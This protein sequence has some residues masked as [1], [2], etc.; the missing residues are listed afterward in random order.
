MSEFDAMLPWLPD[1]DLGEWKIDTFEVDDAASRWSAVRRE[2]VPPGRYRR[3]KR[4]GGVWM[5]TT[6]FEA[7][8][9]IALF[10]QKGGDILISGLGLGYCAARVLTEHADAKLT[11]VELEPALVEYVGG[12]LQAAFPGRAEVICA[13]ILEWKPP[14]G[15]RWAYAWHDIWQDICTDNLPE[16]ARLKRRFARRCNAQGCWS[17]AL[18]RRYQRA[19]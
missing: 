15:K 14:A 13:D 19:A 3:L 9:H 17:E 1:A 12:H 7:R 5:S 10:C 11:I 18:T 4:N 6:P 8:E 16:M 2:Y